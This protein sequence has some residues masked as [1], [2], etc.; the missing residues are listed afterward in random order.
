MVMDLNGALQIAI[1]VLVTAIGTM[2]TA[3]GLL[4]KIQEKDKEKSSARYEA[5]E[6]RCRAEN[7]RL[8]QRIDILSDNQFQLNRIV[9]RLEGK[10]GESHA[11]MEVHHTP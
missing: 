7:E 8:N 1:G 4:F 2:G 10:H 3:I 11:E 9:G 5:S 6:A